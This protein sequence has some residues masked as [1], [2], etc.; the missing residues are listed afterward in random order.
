[1]RL[2]SYY[3]KIERAFYNG[4]DWIDLPDSINK[5]K[6]KSPTALIIA[7]IYALYMRFV[8]IPGQLILITSFFVVFYSLI[9]TRNPLIILSSTMLSLYMI[10]FIFGFIYRPVLEIIRTIPSRARAGS[11]FKVEYSLKNR[12]RLPCWDLSIDSL[13]LRKGISHYSIPASTEHL[14]P[15]AETTLTSFFISGVRGKHYIASPI[16]ESTFPLGLFKWSTSKEQPQHILIYPKFE[17]LSSIELPSGAKFQKPTM[18]IISKIGESMDFLGCREFRTGDN[19]KF[20]HWRSTA[21]K[22]NLVVREFREECLSRIALIVDTYAPEAGIFLKM[23]GKHKKYASRFEAA[24]SLSAAVA[25]ITARQ[26]FVIDFFAAGP[27]IY[28][29]QGG[30]NLAHLDDI[31]DILAGVS[32]TSSEPFK[33]LEPAVM[34]EISGIGTA[35]V[36]LLKWDKERAEFI[37]QMRDNG[38]FT[39][40]VIVSETHIESEGS[41]I[42][43]SP[44]DINAGKVKI[45]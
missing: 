32:F 10:D 30:R 2:L 35:V 27:E 4:P 25:E 28:H 18:S 24:I 31:L 7:W 13:K 19:P 34:E 22:G 23:T 3:K 8:T 17:A 14:A 44:D 29:F 45:L 37:R 21:R 41:A 20:I 38:V 16:A 12:R 6:Y 42:V 1:M 36:I 5:S 15:G 39:K 11:P 9:S 33:I 40:V 26:D 43:L